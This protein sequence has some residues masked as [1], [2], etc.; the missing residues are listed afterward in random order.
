[1]TGLIGKV[2]MR[3]L[4]GELRLFW[5]DDRNTY[6]ASFVNPGD[7]EVSASGL[8]VFCHEYKATYHRA[9]RFLDALRLF[10]GCDDLDLL[11]QCLQTTSGVDLSVRVRFGLISLIHDGS[12]DVELVDGVPTNVVVG[13]EYRDG[14]WFDALGARVAYVVCR[15]ASDYV[16]V[17]GEIVQVVADDLL[18]VSGGGQYVS[19]LLLRRCDV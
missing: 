12:R 15:H 10:S 8:V 2:R 11:R 17:P 19:P 4:H 6:V 9:G 5:P 3:D 14:A 18:V 7:D 16:N 1:V 13:A